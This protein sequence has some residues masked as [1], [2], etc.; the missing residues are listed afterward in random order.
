MDEIDNVIDIREKLRRWNSPEKKAERER[1]YREERRKFWR[2][3]FKRMIPLWMIL[4]AELAALWYVKT[5]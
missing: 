3:Y 5:H 4:A 1:L 2:G